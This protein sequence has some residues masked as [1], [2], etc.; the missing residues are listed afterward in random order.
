[1]DAVQDGYIPLPLAGSSKVAGYI[2]LEQVPPEV[3]SFLLFTLQ[4]L[5]WPRQTKLLQNVIV[6]YVKL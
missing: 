4:H 3:F 5:K 2:L 1:M 6:A